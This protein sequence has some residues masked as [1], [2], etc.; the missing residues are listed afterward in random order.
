MPSSLRTALVGCAAL[1]VLAVSGAAVGCAQEGTTP[2]CN[3]N[4]NANGMQNDVDDPCNAFGK[5]II[6]GEVRPAADC[7]VDENGDP[8]TGNKLTFCLYGFGAVDVGDAP[9][10]SGGSGAGGG[11]AGGGG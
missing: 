10:G 5:C 9:G 8:F 3:D 2:T 6:G 1:I 4:V 11:G 7:C